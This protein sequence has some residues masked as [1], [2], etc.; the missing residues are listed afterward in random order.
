MAQS[1]RAT[2]D[3]SL[4]SHMHDEIMKILENDQ[5]CYIEPK[6]IVTSSADSYKNKLR[7][8]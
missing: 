8:L 3:T 4:I 6:N 7:D 5:I 1:V 2:H